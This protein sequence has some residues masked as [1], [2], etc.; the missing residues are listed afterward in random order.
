MNHYTLMQCA[1]PKEQMI[2]FIT[3]CNNNLDYFITVDD[4]LGDSEPHSLAEVNEIFDLADPQFKTIA[5]RINPYKR[6]VLA[7][8][9]SINPVV[10]AERKAG[11]NYV[12]YTVCNTL[13][14]FVDLYLNPENPNFGFNGLNVAPFYAPINNISVTYMLEFDTFNT[15][16]KSIPEFAILEDVDFLADAHAACANYKDLYT[17]ASK[18]K[19]AEVFAVDIATWNYT[20]E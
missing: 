13:S 10:D 9:K 3:A 20:F 4:L 6:L 2:S 19:V 14:E 16:V 12:D 8:L 17:E 5:I 1:I 11:P 7:Y 15:D 18:A